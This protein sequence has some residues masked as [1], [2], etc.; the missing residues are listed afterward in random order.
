MSIPVTSGE[1]APGEEVGREK[2]RGKVG[3]IDET[4]SAG[5]RRSCDPDSSFVVLER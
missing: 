1:E 3:Q 2:V 5:G 4:R